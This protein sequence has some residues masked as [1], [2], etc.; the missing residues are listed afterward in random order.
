[1]S[2]HLRVTSH[3]EVCARCGQAAPYAPDD[4]DVRRL[5]IAGYHINAIALVRLMNGM[6]LGQ[7]KDRVAA[8][9]AAEKERTPG[10]S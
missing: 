4:E 7:A 8:I 10:S 6:T 1:M 5:V 2:C 3:H 9:A